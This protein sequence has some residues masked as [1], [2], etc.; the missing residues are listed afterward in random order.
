MFSIF[1][2][3]RP[4]LQKYIR[5]CL[6]NKENT[7]VHIV[8]SYIK[9]YASH[10]SPYAQMSLGNSMNDR[11]RVLRRSWKVIETS[12]VKLTDTFAPVLEITYKLA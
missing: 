11:L 6:N 10:M 5:I 7:N 2:K 3:E 1:K 9:K 12:R 8:E 4:S